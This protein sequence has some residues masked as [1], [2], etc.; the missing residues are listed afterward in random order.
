MG[1]E[2]RSDD[3]QSLAHMDIVLGCAFHGP[4]ERYGMVSVG[5]LETN[6]QHNHGNIPYL[7]F[8]ND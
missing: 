6:G 8:E 3:L 1:W 7:R 4:Q 2:A 5:R